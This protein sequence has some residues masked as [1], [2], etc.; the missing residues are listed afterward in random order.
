[1]L[2]CTNPTDQTEN[3]RVN[4]VLIKFVLLKGICVNFDSTNIYTVVTESIQTPL[5]F[6]LFVILQPFAKII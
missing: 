4:R 3:T 5:N 6:S 1:M 2:I